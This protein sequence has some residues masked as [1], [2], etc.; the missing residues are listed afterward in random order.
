MD[1]HNAFLHDELNEE[2][3]TRIPPGFTSNEFGMV[4]RL[5]KSLYGLKQAPCCWFAKL[6]M[7]LKTYGFA[8]SSSDYSLFTLHRDSIHLLVLVYVDDIIISGNNS[9][10]IWVFKIY[11]SDC[12]YI[13]DLSPLKYFLGMEVARN[14][15]GIFL[16]Q[17]KY[18]LDIISKVG[19][20]GAKPAS[21]PLE[22]NHQLV[23]AEGPYF[24][25]PAKY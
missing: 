3:Y 9:E 6:A 11:L 22:L 25:D 15:T 7:A 17:R 4:C 16:S 5:R 2:V 20:L 21:F 24:S 12:F 13:K 23:L 8:Q 10:A 18:V 19:L 14:P 1:V